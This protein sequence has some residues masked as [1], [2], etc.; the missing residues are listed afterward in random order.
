MSP[1]ARL[2]AEV[3][4]PTIYQ[5]N[6]ALYH[7]L[8]SRVALTAACVGNANRHGFM[9]T[10]NTTNPNEAIFVRGA[11]NT[12][13]NRPFYKKFGWTNDLSYCCDCANE[14][15]NSLRTTFKVNAW[16]GLDTAGQ[17]H[18]SET[19]GRWLGLRLQLLLP[20]RPQRRSGLQ[21]HTA[22]Q[23]DHSR[24]DLLNPRRQSQAVRL[25]PEPRG[26]SG[27]RRLDTQRHHHL[28]QRLPRLD[29]ACKLRRAG[30]PAPHRPQQPAGAK[31][32]HNHRNQWFV[33]GIGNAFGVPA[34][35][36]FGNYPINTLLGPR[37]IQQDMTLSKSF[38][39]T[40][41]F[42][43]ARR[44]DASNAFNHT[45]LGSPSNDM[46]SP[47]AGKIAGIA[48]GGTMRRARFSA[49]LKF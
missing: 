39:L 6:L 36:T 3:R 2:P 45:N 40:E 30:R 25:E 16:Q 33:A 28:L 13:L 27:G 14:H 10:S 7:Q 48:P 20:V 44:A 41:R 46:Q 18:L 15:Y 5:Y 47:N 31:G 34:A 19:V 37:F 1:V 21:Q 17:L 26:R 4:L 35:D 42:S 8:T 32:N 29:V 9:G 11:P 12:D 43:L 24:A 49:T 38:H 22:A 23:P